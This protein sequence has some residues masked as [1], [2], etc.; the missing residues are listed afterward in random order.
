VGFFQQDDWFSYAWY[1]LHRDSLSYVLAFS[2][3]HFNPFTVL[4]NHFLFS[5]WGMNYEAF[6]SVSLFLHTMVIILV[7]H[8][9]KEIFKRRWQAVITA[10][11]FG[12]FAAHYQGT[13]WVVVDISTHLATF[14]GI[15]S[16]IFFLRRRLCFSLVLLIISL[17]FKEITIGLFPLYL[18]HLFISRR[19]GE[20]SFS[21]M[22]IVV[23]LGAAY[24]LFRLVIVLSLN[25]T[26]GSVVVQSQSIAILAYNF[27]TIP[28]KVIS[29]SI[30]SSE[31]L[32]VIAN[33]VGEIL[34]NSI[35]GDV[36]TPSFEVFVVKVVLEGFSLGLSILIL[37]L[38]VWLVRRSKRLEIKNTLLFGLEWLVLN[39]FIFSFAPER[40]GVIATI[41]SRNLY[42][43]SVGTAIFLTS[44]ASRFYDKY[45]LK[46]IWIMLCILVIINA[47]WLN[48]NLTAFSRRGELRR[49]ILSQ[50]KMNYP[51]L[52]N[53]VIFYTESDRA[54]YGLPPEE[55]I[56]PFQSGLGQTLLVWY[57]PE[58]RFPN[59]FFEDRFLWDILEEGYRQSDGRVFGYFRNFEKMAEAVRALDLDY[60]NSII[61]FSYDSDDGRI[62]VTT[63]E[64]IGR[65]SGYF[66]QKREI[67]LTPEMLTANRK[68]DELRLIIDDERQSYWSSGVPY[69]FA[70]EMTIDLG[71]HKKVAQ[72]TIDSYND[73]DQSQVGYR[74][75]ISG[76]GE[77]WQ[78]VF[79]AKRY[80]PGSDGLVDLYFK[81]Q[82]A[83]WLKVEQVGSHNFAPWVVSEL[84]LYE[85]IN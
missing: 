41:D 18:L 32:L 31:L 63:P 26:N 8:L 70:L 51:D 44:V 19:K 65:L 12:I 74:I 59:E 46:I 6:L 75:L 36:G 73:L 78:E 10:F 85:E 56:L 9:S 25:Q 77:N 48:K 81:P 35:S 16:V 23:G 52:P 80:P 45:H 3:S 27:F 15:L 82:P 13:A 67:L 50:I 55:R 83:R 39:S 4:I 30:F 7:Y 58:E 60:Q 47:F 29:Q 21:N 43:V 14:F 72:V 64:I 61:A 2:A 34:P 24:C 28:L 1:V 11:L 42:F 79:Y 5:L 49:E 22:I 84:K 53:K 76:D 40:L 66:S 37:V 33:K 57:Y 20:S 62:R 38:V 69:K 71:S 17:F 68:P 54:F